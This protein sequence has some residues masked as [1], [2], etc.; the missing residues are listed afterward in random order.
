M[1]KIRSAIQ[2]A[3]SLKTAILLLLLIAI[4]STIGTAIPQKEIHDFYIDKYQNSRWLGFINGKYLLLLQLD[5]L[6]TSYWF[7]F[8]LFW[9]GFALI[10]C[11]WRRQFPIIKSALKWIEY[12]DPQQIRKLAIAETI[13]F[14]C[15]EDSLIKINSALKKQGWNLKEYSQ[16]FA[17][18]K[19]VIG[20]IGPP[21]IHLGLILLMIGS[22]WGALYGQKV[23]KFLAPERSF[24]LV[25]NEGEKQITFKLKNFL[26]ERDSAGR[27]EQ[28]KSIVQIINESEK[29]MLNKEVSVN[30]PIRFR[31]L[32]LYQA[33]WSL[34]AINLQINGSPI[35]QLPLKSYPELGEQ[36]WGVVIPTTN[37]L[38][39]PI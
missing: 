21:L 15:E 34:A 32:T 11:S 10:I 39:M 6:Y 9:L 38:E 25:N 1:I 14:E 27:P 17:A 19:G 3:S 2:W 23:E 4:S 29:T 24:D 28:F 22:T 33:D 37:N 20:R 26:I 12:K 7:L 36:V 31:G 16:R 35:L 8:L 18:R 13:D 5:H 30:H